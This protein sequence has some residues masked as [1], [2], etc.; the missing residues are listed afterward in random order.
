[1]KKTSPAWVFVV[2]VVVLP[3]TVFGIVKWYEAGYQSL[4]LLGPQDHR[5]GPFH[6]VNQRGQPVT[7]A[8]TKGKIVVTDFFFTHCPGI[9]PKMT[10]NLQKLQ[11]VFASDNDVLI[12]S[13]SVD[14]LR[15]SVQRLAF[16]AS[17]FHITGNWN[18]LT[19][20]KIEIYR[21]ARKSFFVS[22]TDGDGGPGDFIHSDKL[23]LAD[24]QGQIRGYYDG[25]SESEVAQLVKDIFK[26]EKEKGAD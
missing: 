15:D 9:C 25:T 2:A 24:W 12:N 21:L 10:R 26:L 19:G 8:D 7:D 16:Y 13:F 6:L 5:I 18:L 4:P 1:M 3:V 20:D 17:Q 14:P 23:V 11:A 22:A